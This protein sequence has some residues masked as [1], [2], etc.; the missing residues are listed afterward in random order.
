LLTSMGVYSIVAYTTSLKMREVG[1][2]VALGATPARVVKLILRGAMLPLVA[3]LAVS[4][5]AAL[6]LSQLLASLLYEIS[7]SDPAAFVVAGTVLLLLGVGASARPAWRAAV[8]DP[9]RSLRTD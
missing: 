4:I 8:A 5:G 1:I 9:V 7:A 6:L 3:G 2:R